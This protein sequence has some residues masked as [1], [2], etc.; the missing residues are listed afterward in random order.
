MEPPDR[1]DSPLQVGWIRRNFLT[2]ADKLKTDRFTKYTFYENGK[3]LYKTISD[4]IV[5][6]VEGHY[7]LIFHNDSTSHQLLLLI[8]PAMV[9]S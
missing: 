7:Q 4:D 2:A 9:N 6:T 5:L 1:S 3:Y 8:P